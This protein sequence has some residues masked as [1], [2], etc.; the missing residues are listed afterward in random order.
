MN[1][2]AHISQKATTND[3]FNEALSLTAETGGNAAILRSYEV[4]H[5]KCRRCRSHYQP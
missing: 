3:Q 4:R 2:T 5:S 1:H